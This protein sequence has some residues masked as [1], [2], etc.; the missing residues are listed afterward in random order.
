MHRAC[1][2]RNR[3]DKE[4]A[5]V[6]RGFSSKIFPWVIFF[7][8]YAPVVYSYLVFFSPTS[9]DYDFD[10]YLC[11]GPYYYNNISPWL[12]WY[13]S[14]AHYVLPN[15]LIIVIGFALVIRVVIQ[16]HRLSQSTG[17]RQYRRMTK[18]FVYISLV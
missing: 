17:W 18:Q 9:Y 6:D 1:T 10:L 8:L 12:L 16:K 11:G 7:S 2:V 15:F 14:I 4:N 5:A 3:G 13:E